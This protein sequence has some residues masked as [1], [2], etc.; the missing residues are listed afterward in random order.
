MSSLH[1]VRC[2]LTRGVPWRPARVADL[3]I[4]SVALKVLDGDGPVSRVSIEDVERLDL[5]FKSAT[6]A[7][8]QGKTHVTNHRYEV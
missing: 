8:R 7:R 6:R 1:L 4:R 3:K 2:F 5:T